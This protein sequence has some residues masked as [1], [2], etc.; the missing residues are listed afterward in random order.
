MYVH[1]CVLCPTPRPSPTP[2]PIPSQ[3]PP[4]LV[5]AYSPYLPHLQTFLTRHWHRVRNSPP[6]SL[7]HPQVCYQWNPSSRDKIVRAALP[8]PPLL[9]HDELPLTITPLDT[10]A[11]PC[12]WAPHT[13]PC[14]VCPKL[15]HRNSLHSAA[16]KTTTTKMHPLTHTFS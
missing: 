2:T 3:H 14:T 6:S 9:D 11:T 10:H 12:T 4:C 1:K 8:G 16:S 7:L 13:R 15:L 5:T